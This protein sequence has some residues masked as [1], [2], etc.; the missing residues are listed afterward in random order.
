DRARR[1]GLDTHF[2]ATAVGAATW[3]GA[4]GSIVVMVT[5]ARLGRFWPLTIGL[6]LTALGMWVLHFSG[7]ATL[8]VIAN[9]GTGITWAFVIPYLLGMCSAFDTGGQAPA[10]AGVASQMGLATGPLMGAVLH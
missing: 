6:V 10:F 7:N 5:P 9:C 1:C 2:A 4:L 3:I 8:Y